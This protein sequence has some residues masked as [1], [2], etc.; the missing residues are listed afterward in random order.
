MRKILLLL[1]AISL[2]KQSEAQIVT[3]LIGVSPYQDSLWALDTSAGYVVK[4]RLAPVATSGGSITG[5]TG[6]AKNPNS[7]TIYVICKQS[8]TTGRT[9]GVLDISTGNVTIVGNM[10]DNFSSIT[11][12]GDS[13]FAATGDGASG[14]AESLFLIDTLTADTT[15]LRT[16][17][18][19]ADGEVICYNPYDDMIY[20]WSGNTTVIFEKVLPYPPYTITNIPT[21]GAAGGETF[22]A[23]NISGSKFIRSTI[24]SNFN[25]QDTAGVYSATFGS[26]PDD[27]RGLIFINCDRTISGPTSVCTGSSITISVPAGNSYQWFKNGAVLTGETNQTLSVTTAGNYNCIMS[28]NCGIDST[29]ALVVIENPLPV[30]TLST[31]D[32]SICDGSST[33]L[34][35]SAG[36]SHQWYLSGAAISGATSNTYAA[37]VAGL[38]NMMM[39]DANGCTDSSASNIPV[40]VNP[41]PTVGLTAAL[42]S[43][44]AD[45]M[46]V[47]LTATP[48]GGTL[49]GTGVSGSN[50]DPTMAATGNNTIVYTYT[51]G[52][53]CVNSDTTIIYVDACASI[54]NIG[55]ENLFNVFPNPVS[56]QLTINS[57]LDLI[58]LTLMDITG[59]IVLNVTGN[60][61]SLNMSNLENGIYTL[62]LTTTN[63]QR[64]TIKVVKQ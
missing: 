54:L 11:F 37:T 26:N 59:K 60:V 9:L 51:D 21:T 64:G 56:N 15:F 40:V 17:G 29:T 30:V 61:K 7:G 55:N 13:L 6:M 1:F 50:F 58:R 35:G 62:I 42:D 39:T 44:C 63:L 45:D 12:R 32:S 38:Y 43:V 5:I 57:N 49:T 4:R 34:T 22:G 25:T 31:P 52:N 23:V 48:S 27:L 16:M 20:H 28:D 19:G 2:I 33:V 36:V 24:S 18:A 10:L 14:P 8:A 46:V 3:R 47:I 41:L 53:G